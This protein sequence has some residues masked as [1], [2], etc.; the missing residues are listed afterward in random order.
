MIGEAV[1][2]EACLAADVLAE[3]VSGLSHA[4]MYLEY[5]ADQRLTR[6]GIGKRFGTRNPLDFM[7]PRDVAEHAHRFERPVSA[8]QVA[9]E[10][11]MVFDEPF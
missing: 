1:E 7:A 3:G 4:G 5:V 8:Y 9:V 6:L 11:D 10:G 2:V